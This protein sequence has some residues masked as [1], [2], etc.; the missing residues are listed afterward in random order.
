MNAGARQKQS[1]DTRSNFLLALLIGVSAC[2]LGEPTRIDVFLECPSP[3]A[4]VVAIVWA[5]AGGGAAGWSQQLISLQPSDVPI[6][7]TPTRETGDEAPVLS[8]SSGDGFELK[9]DTNDRLSVTVAYSNRASVYSMSHGQSVRGR[10]IRLVYHERE[11]AGD[12]IS[13]PQ[14][15]CLSGST[16]IE[17][18]APKRLK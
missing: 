17:N 2:G 4:T 3:D 15:K 6:Q 1:G 14:T 11:A 12:P 7:L 5:K 10:Q 18:P 13:A 8:I 9:W 16:L